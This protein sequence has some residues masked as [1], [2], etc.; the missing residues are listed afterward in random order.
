[1]NLD[2]THDYDVVITDLD[3]DKAFPKDET[4]EEA[5]ENTCLPTI[6]EDES[7]RSFVRAFKICA[8][9]FNREN[10]S[11]EELK[12]VFATILN[13]KAQ[14]VDKMQVVNH[15]REK[16]EFEFPSAISA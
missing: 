3:G 12:H 16:I 5:D 9:N 15:I 10:F 8:T 4:A 13:Y 1:M 6:E 2:E 14:F 7:E 11:E